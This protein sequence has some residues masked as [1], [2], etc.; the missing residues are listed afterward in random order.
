MKEGERNKFKG[1]LRNVRKLRNK[2]CFTSSLGVNTEA[3]TK[4]IPGNTKL[5]KS[6]Q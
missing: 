3:S 6:V 4:N 5:Y 1:R 2:F